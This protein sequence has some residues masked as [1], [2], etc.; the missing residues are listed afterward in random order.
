[1]IRLWLNLLLI[2]NKRFVVGFTKVFVMDWMYDGIK[3]QK[4][5]Y[6]LGKKVDKK[7]NETTDDGNFIEQFMFENF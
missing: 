5:D 7:F 6:L 2:F 1:M 4:E 3:I